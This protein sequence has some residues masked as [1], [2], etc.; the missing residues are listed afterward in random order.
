M[1]VS[2]STVVMGSRV[3]TRSQTRQTVPVKRVVGAVARG[4][5]SPSGSE[6]R[7]RPTAEPR[8]REPGW[9]SGVRLESRC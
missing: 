7:G 5:A 9:T 8:E 4:P 2:L 3:H 1:E 6:E